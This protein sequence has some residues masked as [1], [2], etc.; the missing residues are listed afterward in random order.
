VA[1]IVD[2]SGFPKKGTHSVKGARQYSGQ[3]SKQDICRAAV[4]L[5]VAAKVA[6]GVVLANDAYG[7]NTGFGGGLTELGLQYVVGVCQPR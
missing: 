2:D 3:V 6:C 4:S 5:P 7:I 1:W